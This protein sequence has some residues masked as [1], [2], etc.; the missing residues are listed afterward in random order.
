MNTQQ[1]EESMC[2][3]VSPLFPTRPHCPKSYTQECSTVC[4]LALSI[5]KLYEQLTKISD[6]HSRF[7][8]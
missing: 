1:S 7:K 2:H 6:F 3:T 5:K 4:P 8:E